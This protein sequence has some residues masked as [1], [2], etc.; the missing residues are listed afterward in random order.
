MQER[1]NNMFGANTGK[2]YIIGAKQ[3]KNA[4]RSGK[5]AGVYIASDCDPKIADPVV[6]LAEEKNLPL[7][8]ISTMKELGG[9]CGIDV[10]ASCAAET[11]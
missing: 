11:I 6:G 4:I 1:G 10:K 7:F 8:Y 2:R 3:V 5:A 9:M